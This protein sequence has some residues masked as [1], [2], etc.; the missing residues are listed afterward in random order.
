MKPESSSSTVKPLEISSTTI[1]ASEVYITSTATSEKSSTS[2]KPNNEETIIGLSTSVK[3]LEL[4]EQK[5]A[6]PKPSSGNYSVSVKIIRKSIQIIEKLY[7]QYHL[8]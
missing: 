7:I 4:G 8:Q 1:K 6:E 5:P 3:P 2:L